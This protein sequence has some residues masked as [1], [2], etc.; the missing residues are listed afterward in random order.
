MSRL[1]QYF[2]NESYFESPN[3]INS[4]VAG[5]IASDGHIR[6]RRHD[7]QSVLII[8]LKT[9]DAKLLEDI[10]I[11]VNSNARIINKE[12]EGIIFNKKNNKYYPRIKKISILSFYSG[13]K[14]AD[15]LYRNWT[16]NEG[17]KSLTLMPPNNLNDMDLCLAYISGLISGDGSIY[18]SYSQG[19]KRLRIVALGTKEL[20][21][22]IRFVY[23][24]F[25]NED[26]RGKV[27]KEKPDSKI[28]SLQIGDLRA[29]K[30]IE[31]I[32]SLNCIK[33]ERKWLKPEVLQY[34]KEKRQIPFFIKRLDNIV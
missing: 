1:K 12:Q 6:E 34:I 31:K 4:S 28:Y 15:D 14:W 24:K 11:S 22:W 32:N 9:N 19:H 23:C 18:V 3:T 25:F 16:I 2:K 7:R 21:D 13:N 20:L 10:K 33:L 26:I 5:I 27:K 30:L 8:A 29:I 17:K